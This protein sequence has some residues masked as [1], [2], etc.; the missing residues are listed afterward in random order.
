MRYLSKIFYSIILG[1]VLGV[2]IYIAFISPESSPHNLHHNAGSPLNLHPSTVLNSNIQGCLTES[3]KCEYAKPITPSS[4]R[5]NPETFPDL[6]EFQPIIVYKHA[7]VIR[8]SYGNQ[9]LDSHAKANAA[10]LRSWHVWF[11]AYV[12]LTGNGCTREAQY[13][14]NKVNYIGGI[15]GPIIADAEIALPSGYVRCFDNYISSHSRYPSVTYS[16]CYSG[17]ERYGPAWIPNYSSFPLCGP[18]VAWQKTDNGVCGEPWA[19]DCSE[20]RGIT[21]LYPRPICNAKCQLDKVLRADIARRETNRRLSDQYIS[22]DKAR[23]HIDYYRINH[24]RG[25]DVQR[26]R[27]DIRWAQNNI[28]Y[29]QHEVQ[30][31][32]SLISYWQKQL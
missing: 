14:I 23:I 9:F 30:T 22:V 19:G 5:Y 13:A 1:V 18:M 26:L 17:D 25:V 2:L 29:L 3:G 28:S 24:V 7:A 31:D 15:N 20:N 27:G 32:N 21:A 6:S 4:K 16:G 11:G 8:L 12:Y 10:K